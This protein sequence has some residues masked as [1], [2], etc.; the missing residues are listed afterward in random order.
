M[1]SSNATAHQ[2]PAHHHTR[3]TSSVLKSIIN[4]RHHKRN[5]SAG[6]GLAKPARGQ[7]TKVA[8]YNPSS[9][10]PLLPLDHPVTRPSGSDDKMPNEGETSSSPSKEHNK[11]GQVPT[12]YKTLHKKTL[13]SISLSSLASKHKDKPPKSKSKQNKPKKSKSHTNLSALLSRSGSSKSAKNEQD[14]Q[15]Q[16]DKENLTPP[17]PTAASP[18]IYAQFASQPF[19]RDCN[20]ETVPFTYFE[21]VRQDIS[22][23]TPGVYSPSQQ[24]N[25]HNCQQPTLG[26]RSAAPKP[27]PQSTCVLVSSSA[28]KRQTPDMRQ[29]QALSN[30]DFGGSKSDFV[31]RQTNPLS[32]STPTRQ[33]G[34]LSNIHSSIQHQTRGSSHGDENPTNVK[35]SSKVM[36]VVATLNEKSNDNKYTEANNIENEFEALLDSRNVPENMRSKLRSLEAHI[37]AD[38]IKQDRAENTTTSNSHSSILPT[39]SRPGDGSNFVHG[40]LQ[41]PSVL[42]EDKNSTSPAKRGRP[43]SRT[44]TFSKGD[45]EGRSSSKKQRPESAAG[46]GITSG[47][48]SRTSSS[49]SLKSLNSAHSAVAAAVGTPNSSIPEDFVAYLRKV[50]SPQKVEVGKLHKLRLVLRNERIVWV[51]SFIAMGGMTEVVNLLQRIMDVE[52]REEHEDALLHE[53]LLCFKALCTTAHA[54]ER[55]VEIGP[56]LFPALLRMLFDEERK[57]PSEFTTRG[58]VINLLFTHLA[59]APS[60]DRAKRAGTILNYLRDPGLRDEPQPLGFIESMHQT[61]PYRVWCKEAVNVTKEVFWIFLHNLNVIPMT[62]EA[63]TDRTHNY[64]DA[65]FPKERPP[66]PAAPYVG[67]VEWDATNYVANHLD[68]MNGLIASLATRGERDSLRR[69]L[70]ASGFE[71]MMGVSLRTCKE[72]FYGAVHDGLRTWV[73]AAADDGW[74]IKDVRMGPPADKNKTPKA[75]PKKNQDQAPKLELPKLELGVVKKDEEGWL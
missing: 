20:Q 74:D 4:P 58:I 33:A 73:A 38:F 43:R 55:L 19:Q 9:M 10:L 54:L 3:S 52:W 15:D 48:M 28:P 30:A 11:T 51:D 61:R 39:Q 32:C 13:S 23:Y 60:N 45:K 31:G 36:A 65:H 66:V 8:D 18:P 49:K 70:K 64:H 35:R 57:G 41:S 68:L 46:E 25:F 1:E 24:R 75:S 69:D 44:F 37:K 22:L 34:E 56:T 27:R 63:S 14:M 71:K 29:K 50:Q 42:K 59:S 72:K 40:T 26:K 12:S 16:H 47:P 2:R 5:A 62:T 7:N 17:H 21:D 6:V 67:G 53:V